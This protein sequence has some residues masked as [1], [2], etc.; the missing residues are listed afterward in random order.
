MP[1]PVDTD[2][3]P[4]AAFDKMKTKA[5][6]KPEP[7]DNTQ[8]V[9]DFRTNGGQIFHVRPDKFGRRG[10]TFAFVQRGRRFELATA[11]QHSSDDF[12]KKLG[13][14]TAIEHFNNGKTIFVPLKPLQ[15][16]L[17]LLRWWL[18]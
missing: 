16:P 15:E 14:K 5:L 8:L 18:M 10:T 12:T 4:A 3:I 2:R 7:I 1:K 17:H 11:V 6:N 13:T 9:T